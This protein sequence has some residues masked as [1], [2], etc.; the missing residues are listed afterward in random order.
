MGADSVAPRASKPPNTCANPTDV[1]ERQALIDKT[2]GLLPPPAAPPVD[3]VPEPGQGQVPEADAPAL[4]PAVQPAAPATAAS[5]PPLPP[6]PGLLPLPP[7]PQ[8]NVTT[9]RATGPDETSQS[10][11]GGAG[12]SSVGA[13]EAGADADEDDDEDDVSVGLVV[14]C[15]VAAAVAVALCVTAAAL[16]VLRRQ[17]QQQQQH[18][19][20]ANPPPQLEEPQAAVGSWRVCNSLLLLWRRPP[21]AHTHTPQCS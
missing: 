11:G 13:E 3:T 12:G 16:F 17:R 10:L 9:T 20:P 1:Q 15:A 14:G 21:H 6:P 4:N 8:R 7:A 19:P 5:P 2:P 18:P